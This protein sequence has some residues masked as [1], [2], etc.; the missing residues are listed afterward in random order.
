LIFARNKIELLNLVA[1]KAGEKGSAG[2]IRGKEIEGALRSKFSA[3]GPL[4]TIS[5]T[6]VTWR[7]RPESS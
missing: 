4:G 1:I 3:G 6:V 5:T 7:K 2:T